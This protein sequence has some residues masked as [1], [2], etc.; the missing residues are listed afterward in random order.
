MAD[1]YP[2]PACISLGSSGFTQYPLSV[3]NN[4]QATTATLSG[5][6]W[7]SSWFKAWCHGTHFY[8]DCSTAPSPVGQRPQVTLSMLALLGTTGAQLADNEPRSRADNLLNM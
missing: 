5:L 2:D 8:K 7:L 6:G 3:E 4:S 1:L